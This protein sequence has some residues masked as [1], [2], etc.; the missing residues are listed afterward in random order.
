MIATKSVMRAR[1]AHKQKYIMRLLSSSLP[2]F[3]ILGLLFV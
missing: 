1:G 2:E 3:P